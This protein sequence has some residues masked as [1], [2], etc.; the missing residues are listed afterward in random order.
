MIIPVAVEKLA[1][2]EFAKIR[3]RQEALQTIS[4]SFLDIFYHP[5][6][7]IFL[8]TRVFQQPPLFATSILMR[9]VEVIVRRLPF[10]SN[11]RFERMGMVVLRSTTPCVKP[12][13]F[14]QVSRRCPV[15]VRGR[16]P[17]PVGSN[18]YFRPSLLCPNLN[19]FLRLYRG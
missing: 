17:R 9:S 16:V 3:S 11:K 8:K 2:S 6:F 18:P 19:T 1:H 7:E 12:Q 4:P 13:L 10:A 14:E 5:F 15:D